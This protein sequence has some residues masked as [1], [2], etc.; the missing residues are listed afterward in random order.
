[1][2]LTQVQELK[3]KLLHEDKLATVWVFFLDHFGEN[4]DFM[5]LGEQTNHP[6]VEAVI[7]EVGRHMFGS[8][9]TIDNLRLTRIADQNF[10]HGG[11]GMGD[12]VGGVIFFE[13]VQ[14]GLVMAAESPPSIDVKYARFLGQP[15]RRIPTPSLN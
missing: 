9:T 13:D 6:F 1:M 4:R 7:S 15:I 8:D 11:F 10:V 2:D 5:A 12:H 14:M 3:Q